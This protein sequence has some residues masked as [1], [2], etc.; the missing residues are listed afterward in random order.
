MRKVVSCLTA[1]LLLACAS[2]SKYNTYPVSGKVT[3]KGFPASGA[4]VFFFRQGADSIDEPPIMGVVREDGSF[5][6]GKGR[7]PATTTS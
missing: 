7:L 3:Y 4:A 6:L 1:G 5:E 2:C